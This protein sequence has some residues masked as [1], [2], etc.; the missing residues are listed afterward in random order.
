MLLNLFN[1]LPPLRKKKKEKIFSYIQTTRTIQALDRAILIIVVSCVHI[2]YG[3]YYI[4]IY[5]CVRVIFYFHVVSQIASMYNN[6]INIKYKIQKSKTFSSSYKFVCASRTQHKYSKCSSASA[7][8][9]THT[10][11]N[12]K[13]IN[14]ILW[15]SFWRRIKTVLCFWIKYTRS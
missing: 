10:H 4:Y 1:F 13:I 14:L 2:M 3:I 11:I 7:H 5:C 12:V 6:K 8:A 15:Y 9:Y